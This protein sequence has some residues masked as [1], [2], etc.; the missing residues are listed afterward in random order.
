MPTM[1]IDS[2]TYALNSSHLATRRDE[3]QESLR[4][5]IGKRRPDFEADAAARSGNVSLSAAARAAFAGSLRTPASVPPPPQSPAPLA[6]ADSAPV[7]DVDDA[8]ANDPFLR[9]IISMVEM[10]TGR[11]IHVFSAQ[12]MQPLSAP[13]AVADPNA[14]AARQAVPDQAAGFGIEYDYHAVHEEYEQTQVSA[15]GVVRTA[16]GREIA[17]TLDLSMTRSFREESTISLRAGNA[18]RKDPLVLNFNGLAAQLSDRRFAFDLDSNGTPENIAL[19]TGGSGYLAFDRNGNGRIESGSELFGPTTGSGFAELA[20]LDGDDNGWI[21]ENDN[22]FARLSV[23]TPDAEGDGILEPLAGRKVGAIAL[24]SVA[25]P[26]QLRG[27]ENS[28]LGAIAASG[29]FLAEDGRAGGIQEIDL[30]IG[31]P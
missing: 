1:K 9:L 23:W 4:M 14:A 5:W 17:F 25:S 20:A 3:V 22:A 2:A 29:L 16:D 19:L 30:T 7:A 13:P 26:F 28:D 8:V 11:Q 31:R 12:D 27:A 21:D 10:L 24:G 6:M 18:V 15:Q